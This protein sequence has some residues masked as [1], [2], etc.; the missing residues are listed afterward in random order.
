M[1]RRAA[2]FGQQLSLTEPF[3]HRVARTVIAEMGGHYGELRS[4]ADGITQEILREEERFS[5]TLTRGIGEL[6][7]MLAELPPG[8]KLA[9]E[10]AF[11]LYATLGL[12]LQ[13]TK[14][15]SNE[16]GHAVD[17]PGYQAAE[18]AHA[19]ISGASLA[20]DEAG[21]DGPALL[22][23]LKQAGDLPE[24]GM[25]YEPYGPLELATEAL[26]FTRG[27]QLIPTAI[28]GETVDVL[29]A[30]QP[31]YAEAGG[32][33]SDQG[34]I[35]GEGWQV[36][37][38]EVL[39][40]LDDWTLL[41]G[42]VIEGQPRTGSV[43]AVID[44]ERRKSITR[45]HTAT[46]LLHAALR[47]VLGD[48]VQ[49][50]GSLVAPDRLRFDFTHGE[51]LSNATLGQVERIVNQHILANGRVTACQRSL[52]EARRDGAMA[53]FGEKYGEEVRTVA[54]TG[55]AGA[56]FSYELCGGLH[57]TQTAEI[58]PFALISEGSVSAGV[59]RVEALTGSVALQYIR[60][61]RD[62]LHQVAEALAVQ[63]ERIPDRLQSLQR[64]LSQLKRRNSELERSL[65]QQQ[66]REQLH[67]L[68]EIGPIPALI[69]QFDGTPM[70]TM[71]EMADWFRAHHP[72]GI[73]ILG[74]VYDGKP[75]LLATV[76]D[77]WQARGLQAG[78]LIRTIAPSIGGGGG[79]RPGMAQ[80][81]GSNP[82]GI[83]QAL[84]EARRYLADFPL[85]S[86]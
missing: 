20:E 14:D 38:Q 29:L 75:Q 57:V 32:Q 73:L 11:Y 26:A 80:A 65:A 67:R 51:G 56:R 82:V 71:R 7:A 18:A 27:G 62:R 4:I 24:N 8:G 30:R 50:R 2:R 39:R 85:S 74:S 69:T 45:N 58:G 34:K 54:I 40:P 63:E 53:L 22:Q 9:G 12:P 60:E 84:E 79:G 64:E 44:A 59:R 76:S 3:L 72:S 78:Q 5:Q 1:I 25:S 35:I 33:V 13:V 15:I 66:F 48:H 68:E 6:D 49:Q 36:E 31:F 17:L 47:Q 46:H 77:D 83:A 21:V 61:A 43:T 41:H 42:E 37:V 81:G 23:Q 19:A 70:A 86:D 28:V 55:L 52:E 10:R 16:R